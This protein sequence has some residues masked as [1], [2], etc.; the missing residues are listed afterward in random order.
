MA[1]M[2]ASLCSQLL[3]Q[4]VVVFDGQPVLNDYKYGENMGRSPPP[5]MKHE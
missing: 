1:A 5:K 3:L 2:A 4:P